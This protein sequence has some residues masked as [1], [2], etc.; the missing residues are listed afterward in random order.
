M[1][2]AINAASV[3]FPFL[4]MYISRGVHGWVEMHSH[5]RHAPFRL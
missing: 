2:A 3:I 1:K 4:L 5:S